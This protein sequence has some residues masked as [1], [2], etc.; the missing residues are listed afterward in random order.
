MET[1]I[2]DDDSCYNSK[3][4]KHWGTTTNIREHKMEENRGKIYKIINRL[5]TKQNINLAFNLISFS[6]NGP[7]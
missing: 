1:D 5:T 2:T 3:N 7:F 6:W 4:I